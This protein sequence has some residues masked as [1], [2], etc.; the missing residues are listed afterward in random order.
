MQSETRC[1]PNPVRITALALP[2]LIALLAGCDASE[3]ES[4]PTHI[5]T[6]T[7]AATPVLPAAPWFEPPPDWDEQHPTMS[8]NA[9]LETHWLA[10]AERDAHR[11][12]GDGGG[13][14]WLS[15]VISIEGDAAPRTI[16]TRAESDGERPSVPASSFHRFVIHY[17]VGPEGIAEGG[18]IFLSPEAFWFWSPAQAQSNEAPGFTTARMIA[19]E[20][21]LP[22]V[23]LI[24]GVEL[25]VF[26]VT[27]RALLPGERI[28]F[29]YGA[30]AR[31]AQVDR[32]AE[33]R[34]EIMLAVDSDGNGF[35][36][37]VEDAPR[38]DI[39]GQA[40]SRLVAFG[41]AEVAPGGAFEVVL[42]MVDRRG[43]RATWP[44]TQGGL[45]ASFEFELSSDSTLGLATGLD[46]RHDGQ[47]ANDESRRIRLS[48]APGTGTLRLIVRGRGAFEGF[49]A[50]LPPIVVRESKERLVWG[51]L[52]GH[53]HYSDGT[54]TPA[55]YFAY[56]RDV[57]G[58]DV[59][60][61]TDH[62]HWGPRALDER[63]DL[64]NAIFETTNSAEIPGSFI[65]IPGYEWTSWI[66]GHR[67]VLF[68]DP[69]TDDPKT[70]SP[71]V[72]S[73]LDS[74]TDRP[75][76]LW[77][78]LRGR[79][80]LTF[81][82]HSAGEPVATN[83][84]YPPDPILEPVT[85]IA[86][87]HGQS[88]SQ[89]VE[90]AIRGGIPGNYVSDAIAHGYRLGFIGSGDSHDGHPGLAQIAAGQ[91]GLAGLFTRQLDRKSVLDALRRRHTFATN[92]IRPFLSVSIND[93]PMGGTLTA[94][95]GEAEATLSIRF[96][97][98]DVI[99]R[100]E[101]VRDGHRALIEGDGTRSIDLTRRIPALAPGETHYVRILQKNGGMAWS[102][103]I[104]VDAE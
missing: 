25:A 14:G 88:E 41:P 74:A 2:L 84:A 43:N 18:L 83:W 22:N 102:S 23:E 69:T 57:A 60:A 6:E 48:V 27:G 31:G 35:R 49:D 80:A 71:P 95:P 33:R 79:D 85:E 4:P 87:V 73:S 19:A 100:I 54:G 76:E 37:W 97:G 58:L 24:P 11:A 101:L 1:T 29:V 44:D 67:H 53:T 86:S 28:E 30:G 9:K 46:P 89:D 65:T 63:P 12:A 52:H 99:E 56:A 13:R 51:D 91:S 82:H 42:S 17:E 47:G 96:E 32:Y 93:T 7:S 55:D 15:E 61:L 16:W 5:A 103:P 50:E 21:D 98:T 66:H 77:Q 75:D 68:F 90:L 40:A 8:P 81:A 45:D 26:R 64:M 70:P 20:E 72:F 78:A 3:T 94:A 59:I 104:F 34:A 10:L 62:D 92:G 38:L 39:H 36:K